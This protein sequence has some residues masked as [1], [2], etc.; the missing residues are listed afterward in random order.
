M[1]CD[2]YSI[3]QLSCVGYTDPFNEEYYQNINKY[4]SSTYQT[5][6]YMTINDIR[7]SGIHKPKLY[8]PIFSSMM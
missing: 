3:H 8:Q 2:W 5:F 1:G 4:L 7:Y 6:I